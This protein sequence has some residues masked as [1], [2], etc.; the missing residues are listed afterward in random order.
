LRV[1]CNS[2]ESGNFW[3]SVVYY[4]LVCYTK[5]ITIHCSGLLSSR[6]FRRFSNVCPRC[7]QA[8]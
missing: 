4:S 5:L 2:N 3:L 1:G 7:W 8:V 6:C